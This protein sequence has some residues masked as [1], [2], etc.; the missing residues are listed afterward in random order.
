MLT[1][2]WAGKF[3]P[4]KD[5]VHGFSHIRRVCRLA[6][7]IGT[8][9]GADL[10]IV[11][12]AALLHDLEGDVDER[13]DHQL[14]AAASAA[15]LLEQEGWGPQRT[16]A[17]AHC[18]RSHRF[19][20]Q[21]EPPRSLEAQVLFDADKLDAIGALG[22]A[23]AIAYA[24]RAGEPIYQLPSPD[25][26]KS[27]EKAQGEAHTPYHEYLTKLRHIKE[28]LFTETGR[29]LAR[30]RHQVMVEFFQQWADELAQTS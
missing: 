20:D 7:I 11:R 5:P 4:E 16:A 17:V 19:R 10:E 23:R 6:E 22:A 2:E 28:R 12:A 27:G 13:D 18:I 29:S 8:A 30:R 26:L 1:V 21:R 24:V 9:E 3:Y 14:A 15:R 25:F